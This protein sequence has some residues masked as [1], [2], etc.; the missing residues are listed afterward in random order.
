MAAVRAVQ[1]ADAAE[2]AW[3]DAARAT[4]AAAADGH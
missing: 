1:R 3:R 2:P 4:Q